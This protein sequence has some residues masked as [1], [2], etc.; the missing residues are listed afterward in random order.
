[1]DLQ[2]KPIESEE[3]KRTRF[4]REKLKLKPLCSK[5]GTGPFIDHEVYQVNFLFLRRSNPQ[6]PWTRVPRSRMSNFFNYGLDEKTFS[7]YGSWIRE[8]QRSATLSSEQKKNNALAPPRCLSQNK[9]HSNGET[10]IEPETSRGISRAQVYEDD[11][12]L[13]SDGVDRSVP[14]N[15]QSKIG[16]VLPRMSSS[17]LGAMKATNPPTSS[18]PGKSLS[19]FL[20][21]VGAT[22]NLLSPQSG[23]YMENVPSLFRMPSPFSDTPRQEISFAQGKEFFLP[24]PFFPFPPPSLPVATPTGLRLVPPI[25]ISGEEEKHIAPDSTSTT[26]EQQSSDQRVLPQ[27]LHRNISHNSADSTQLGNLFIE[28]RN[29]DLI[30]GKGVPSDEHQESLSKTPS[31]GQE[32]SSFLRMQSET[33]D[34]RDTM[35]QHWYPAMGTSRPSIS[36]TGRNLNPLIVNPHR[37]ENEKSLSERTDVE[38]NPTKKRKI[39]FRLVPKKN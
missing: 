13:P 1:M 6:P 38:Q 23:K 7:A 4:L 39:G 16:V 34:P 11:S 32:N 5:S 21:H 33:A 31:L 14:N 2:Y 37:K 30:P 3:S 24:H 28:R 9:N 10:G 35:K 22:K 12:K 25:L 18:F 29:Q 20:S 36:T 15:S 17:S 19:L 8:N 26:E 27:E